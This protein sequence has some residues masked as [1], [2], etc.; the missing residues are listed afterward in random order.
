MPDPIDIPPYIPGRDRGRGRGQGKFHHTYN[1]SH[2]PTNTV[3]SVE[4]LSDEVIA[5]GLKD[6]TVFLHDVR[7]GGS[8]LRLRHNGPVARICRVDEWRVVVGGVHSVF[9]PPLIPLFACNG[10]VYVCA[11]DKKLQMY[12]LRYPPTK[13]NPNPNSKGNKNYNRHA[14]TTTSTKP[15]LVFQ[16]YSPVNITP[17]FDLNSQLGILANGALPPGL[18]IFHY[19]IQSV[20]SHA[21][22]I[23]S[24]ASDEHTIQLFS[25]RTGEQVSSSPS[26]LSRYRYPKGISS[27]CFEPGGGE[28][29][30]Q[31]PQTPGLL[32]CSGDGVDEW[33]W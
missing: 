33:R 16:D 6:S 13:S 23:H 15:Y 2:R 29:G 32:V 1:R 10:L 26:P 5:A 20:N 19:I 17:E 12:D 4:W 31:G 28:E 24:V 11:N 21:N 14:S 25:L 9:P 30:I 27:V 3:T 18:I 8:A 22:T 7:S